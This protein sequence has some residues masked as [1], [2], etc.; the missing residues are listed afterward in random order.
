MYGRLQVVLGR[1]SHNQGMGDCMPT[2][3]KGWNADS[4][5]VIVILKSFDAWNRIK[6]ESAEPSITKMR[7]MRS[8]YHN[9]ERFEAMSSLVK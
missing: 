9:R 4:T 5:L 1:D 7:D 6:E 3:L 8:P 2:P